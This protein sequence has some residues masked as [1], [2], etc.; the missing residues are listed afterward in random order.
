MIELFYTGSKNPDDVQSKPELSLGAY[1][2]PVNVPS[3]KAN[4]LF[5][6]ITDYG[7]HAN[8]AKTICIAAKNT[9]SAE[10]TDTKLIFAVP[11]SATCNFDVAIVKPNYDDDNKAYFEDIPNRNAIPM[12]A[13]FINVKKGESKELIAIDLKKGE[14][15]GIWIVRRLDSNLYGIPE[16]RRM[17]DEAIA[18]MPPVPNPP[19]PNPAPNPVPVTPTST[20]EEISM[21]ITFD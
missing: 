14:S 15:F 1:I 13:E 3:G 8:N 10:V 19:T 4:N 17:V 6:D 21:K 18:N 11:T 9:G 5:D 16:T 20:V 12:Y 2:S 7:I